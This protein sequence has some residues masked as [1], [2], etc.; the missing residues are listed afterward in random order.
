M[1]EAQDLI[2][3]FDIFGDVDVDS[4]GTARFDTGL[5]RDLRVPIY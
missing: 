4:Q 1:D 5:G 3:R 2:K